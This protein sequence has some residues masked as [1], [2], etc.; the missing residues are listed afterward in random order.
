MAAQ[1]LY[2]LYQEQRRLADDLSNANETLER[3][4]LQFAGALIATLDARDRYTAGHSAAVAIYSRDISRRMGL[5]DE[6]QE[7]AFLCGLV[8]DI[9]KIGL[10]P[11]LIEKPGAYNLEERRQMQ[12]HSAIGERIL[13]HVNDYAETARVVRHHH[14]RIDGQGYPDGIR[15]EEIPIV[16]RII[17]VA[18]AYNAMT[19][20]RPYRDAMPSRVARVRL[21]QAVGSQFDTAVVAAF[22]AVLATAD[23]EYRLARRADFGAFSQDPYVSEVSEPSPIADVA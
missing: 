7:H 11:G 1:R 23:E 17:A 14:E 3:A 8:H 4:N 18:D 22:E 10:P 16:S 19:S 2:G 12:E 20:D 5:P 13:S 6:V 15:D 21:A 9:G